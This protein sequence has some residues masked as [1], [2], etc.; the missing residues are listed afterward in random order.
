MHPNV[1]LTLSLCETPMTRLGERDMETEDPRERSFVTYDRIHMSVNLS[2]SP[3]C[4]RYNV[5]KQS[6]W[7][8]RTKG[9]SSIKC[10]H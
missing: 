1:A 9:D 2:I 4:H 7:Y 5:Q 10:S 8:H 3:S 6:N